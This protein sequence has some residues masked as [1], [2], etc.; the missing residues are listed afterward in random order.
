MLVTDVTPFD[1][2]VAH[3]GLERAI[4]HLGHERRNGPLHERERVVLEEPVGSPVASRTMVPPATSFV[5]RVIARGA[6]RSAIG[7]RHVPVDALEPYGVVRVTASI[8]ALVGQL[9]TPVRVVPPAARIHA[10]GGTPR[11]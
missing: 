2:D 9:A 8:H 6:E 4:A 5:S 7:E 3:R 1:G 10:P 11:A